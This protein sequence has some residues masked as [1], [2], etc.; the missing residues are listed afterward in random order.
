MKIKKIITILLV[1]IILLNMLQIK[2]QAIDVN[3]AHLEKLGECERYLQ[4]ISDK[5]G[6][7]T[8]IITTMVGYKI[9]DEVHYAYCLNAEK[10]GVG[11]SGSYG[12][13]INNVLEDVRIWRAII[14]GFPYKTPNEM[15]VDN[16]GDAYVATKQA[17]YSVLYNR[18]VDTFYRGIDERGIQIFNAIKHIVNE[19]RNG[20]YTPKTTNLLDVL[21]VGDFK[22]ENEEYYSQ[23]YQVSSSVEINNYDITEITGFPKGSYIQELGKNFKV[24]I[25]E[26]NILD[27]IKGSIKIEASAKTYPVFF[28]ESPNTN[29]Q[30][31]AL[32]YGAYTDV[33]GQVALEI[34]AYKSSL[35]II[36]VDEETNQPI[37]NVEFNVKYED[38]AEIGNFT[39]DKDGSIKISGLK[40]G[41]VVITEV[42][43]KN[44][45]VLNEVPQQLEI[46]YNEE[47]SITISNA[48]KKGQIAIKKVDKE[49]TEI[50]LEGVEFQIL[51]SKNKII[52]TIITD[53][54]GY[55]I[56][57]K[58]P[59][60]E[61]KIKEVK[62]NEEYLLNNE[63]IEVIIDSEEIY[64][65]VVVNEKIKV[66]EPEEPTKIEE[67]TIPKLPV[68]G[69]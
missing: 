69:K 59:I 9:G 16:E 2:V 42:K 61:Y 7:W 13:N 20:T 58:L 30:N 27:N 34:D 54:S 44:E 47:I 24:L 62:T 35:K 68:T 28:G 63:V 14:N 38:G 6:K 32:T 31:Y 10:P 37:S 64:E 39:T 3:Y 4:K 56:T 57:S 19:A 29:L 36:K 15:G 26:E 49:N 22:K 11:E 45:Y 60:G 52:E 23:E 50:T 33:S 5:T 43:T 8:Y 17:I 18:D 41:K 53:K 51:D 21:P 46:G 66:E 40:Q 12:V 67:P 1:A 55:A 25:P 65:I 48:L